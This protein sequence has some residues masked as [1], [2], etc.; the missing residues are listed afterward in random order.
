MKGRPLFYLGHCLQNCHMKNKL[1]F[2]CPCLCLF[3]LYSLIL[4]E[5]GVWRRVS[6][7]AATIQ[8]AVA[9]PAAVQCQPARSS[10]KQWRDGCISGHHSHRDRQPGPLHA[11]QTGLQ[12][13]PLTDNSAI[14]FTSMQ[15]ESLQGVITPMGC[16]VWCEPVWRNLFWIIFVFCL[17]LYS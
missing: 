4:P 1:F 6:Q 9:P 15:S 10:N 3:C 17:F 13:S 8:W 16:F 14:R 5:A 11:W 2:H 7:T 12:V